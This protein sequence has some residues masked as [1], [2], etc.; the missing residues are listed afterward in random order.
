MAVAA[1][2]AALLDLFAALDGED[3]EALVDLLDPDVE[4]ADE[5]TASWLRGREA[6]AAYLRAQSGIVTD[7]ASVPSST[8]ARA[9]GSSLC[10]LTFTLRQRYCLGGLER[11]E[12]LTGC[13]IFRMRDRQ[14]RLTLFHLGGV[15]AIAGQAAADAPPANEPRSHGDEIRR[16]RHAAGLSLRALAER[17]NLSPSFLSQVERSLADPSISSLQRVACALGVQLQDLVATSPAPDPI[18]RAPVR[19]ALRDDGAIV[20]AYPRLEH[21]ALEAQVTELAADAPPRTLRG[22]AGEE[23]VFVLEGWLE[24]RFAA[25]VRVLE[26]GQG[27][28]VRGGTPHAVAAHGGSAVRFLTVQT[29]PA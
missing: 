26:P 14:P 8:T 22:H 29:P 9:L 16:R 1:A 17:S 28:H 25:Q 4:L 24:L 12:G 2:E 7:I 21:G 23:F 10:L 3:W 19:V 13:A 6:V 11:R 20:E 15:D 18:Y 27:A 5:L